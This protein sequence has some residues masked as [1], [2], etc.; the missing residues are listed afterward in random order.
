MFDSL[1]QS[2]PIEFEVYKPR[3][4]KPDSFLGMCALYGKDVPENQPIQMILSLTDRPDKKIEVDVPRG[5]L[6]VQLFK[7][8][9]TLGNFVFHIK[10]R[11]WG[12]GILVIYEDSGRC[13]FSIRG[14]AKSREYY[15]KDIKQNDILHIK[16]RQPTVA[17]RVYYL[18]Q[19]KTTNILLILTCK[20][21]ATNTNYDIRI[22][23]D[24][25]QVKG[26]YWDRLFSC[27]RTSTRASV[28]Y[29]HR[30]YLK[31]NGSE[32]YTVEILPTENVPLFLACTM[33]IEHEEVQCMERA[34]KK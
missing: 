30:D 4:L 11:S 23:G 32:S 10:Q 33:L 29:L 5:E 2:L 17:K 22:P 12:Y 18:F 25:L 34:A 16:R 19:P 7:A 31:A 28:A 14:D 21:G 15:L 27:C 26:N 1:T 13:V 9:R 24:S 20:L 6:K 8:P 3:I